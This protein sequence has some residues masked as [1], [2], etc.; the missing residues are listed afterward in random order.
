MSQFSKTMSYL[1]GLVLVANIFA[2]DP[3]SLRHVEKVSAQQFEI[4]ASVD[5][6]G[7]PIQSV[8]LWYTIDQGRTWRNYGMG[9][10]PESPIL[11]NATEQ[12]LY[13]F[14]LIASNSVGAS[15]PDPGPA[16]QPHYWAYVDYTPPVVQLHP[17]RPNHSPTVP[18]TIRIRWSAID[19]ALSARPIVLSYRTLPDGAWKTL[20]GPMSNTGSYDWRVDDDLTG[21]A[22]VR[23]SVRDQGE[24]L[25]EVSSEPFEIRRP[26]PI[27]DEP[28]E[29]RLVREQ[30]GSTGSDR[31]L[32][33]DFDRRRARALALYRKGVLHSLRGEYHLAASRLS[34]A[35]TVNSSFTDA[36]VEL[37][38][39][40]Y[41]Q[42]EMAQSTEAYHLALRQEPEL[43]SALQGLALT[44]I[45]QRQFPEAV[46]Q[47][48]R[49]VRSNPKDVEAW[50]NLG[51]VA[52]Y[53]GDELL[54][55]EH[56]EKAAM[57]NPSAP[58]IIAKAKLRLAELKRL[59]ADF[60]QVEA[61][62]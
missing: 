48:G 59:A 47:L 28:P 29:I 37:G 39:V 34:E 58:D 9:R 43:R 54:A 4:S 8:A 61:T 52:I 22:V 31:T 15:S 46:R 5:D 56:Y 1:I 60:S 49:I 12:G 11:F 57:L 45:G 36:L 20:E 17:V 33:D 21:M 30:P 62:R 7:E 35:L 51:D 10:D 50:L 2:V 3:P 18:Q 24:H 13:G 16:T 26:E 42:G 40:L 23:I 19:N 41:A 53:Q 32:D 55:R 25:V 44:Y 6:D 27:A 14:F 38:S